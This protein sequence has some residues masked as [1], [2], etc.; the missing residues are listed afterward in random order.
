MLGSNQRASWQKIHFPRIF[1]EQQ[2]G[3]SV[4]AQARRGQLRRPDYERMIAEREQMI[5]SGNFFSP[6]TVMKSSSDHQE[7]PSSSVAQDS[8]SR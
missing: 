2:D 3:R 6:S 5:A 8:T 4:G 1:G 7:M